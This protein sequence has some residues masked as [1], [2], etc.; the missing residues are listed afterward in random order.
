MS[1]KF[2]SVAE[3]ITITKKLLNIL[4]IQD[5]TELAQQTILSNKLVIFTGALTKISRSEA[6]MQAEL[7]GA[8]VT[9]S[10]S[11][12]T[13]LVIAGNDAGVKLKKA[14]E[15]GVKIINE[16]EWTQIVQDNLK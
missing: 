1:C 12:S 6:K 10:V 3:N 5:Y 7:M 15:L 13:D 4:T 8:K 11:S 9:S 2:F 14:T 16:E